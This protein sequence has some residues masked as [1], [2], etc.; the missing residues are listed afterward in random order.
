MDIKNLYTEQLPFLRAELE[1]CKSKL[2][3]EGLT[4]T[5]GFGTN[6]RTTINPTMQAYNTL[7][8]HYLH[9][10]NKVEEL[11]G[12]NGKGTRQ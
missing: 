12:D 9:I 7:L 3:R 1:Q 10:L 11:S 8:S 4:K 6:Q 2:Q 5:A